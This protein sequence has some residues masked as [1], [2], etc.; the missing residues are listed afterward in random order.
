MSKRVLETHPP[1]MQAMKSLKRGSEAID[2]S[3]GIPYFDPPGGITDKVLS[4]APEVNI[5][6]PDAG[7]SDLRELISVRV[8]DRYGYGPDPYRGVVVTSGANIAFFEV[9]SAI[10]DVG[11]EVILLS[12]YYFNHKMALDILGVRSVIVTTDRDHI[13]DIDEIKASITKR[14]RAVVLVSPN[15]PTGV[16]YPRWLLQALGEMCHNSGIYLITDETYEDFVYNGEHH[17]GLRLMNDLEGVISIFSLSKAY[18][19]SGWRIGFTIFPEWIFDSLLKVQ[20]TTVICPTRISQRLAYHILKSHPGPMTDNI[21]YLGENCK[22]VN[23]WLEEN[24]EYINAPKT[25]GAFYSYPS[26]SAGICKG[27][28]LALVKEILKEC[29]VL[30]VP[31]TPFG[32]ED[33]PVFR[34]SFGN[35]RHELLREALDRISQWLEKV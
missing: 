30:V 7:D 35:V 28:P 14:T 33:D 29:G 21:E 6:G 12:P 27:D 10:C 20:D 19:I 5:Y 18:G 25:T 34:I 23:G 17:S 2:L 32:S 22:M 15:N 1:I 8:R 26:V 11:D 4:E 13:P 24:V 16:V 9:I 31:G 3:Q